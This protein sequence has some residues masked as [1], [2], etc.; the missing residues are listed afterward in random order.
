MDAAPALTN[1]QR[2]L[3][4]LF[5][6]ELPEAD[7]LEVRRV[8]ARHFARKASDDFDA[9]ADAHGLSSEA[10]DAWASGHERRTSNP[11]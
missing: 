2:E 11:D 10:T 9:F 6:R 3:L 8:L 5:A 1:L 4:T 7:L